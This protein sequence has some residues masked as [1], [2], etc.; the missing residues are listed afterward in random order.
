MDGSKSL[1]YLR[2]HVLFKT[3]GQS[4]TEIFFKLHAIDLAIGL[5]N[6][7]ITVI[8][9]VAKIESLLCE[10]HYTQGYIC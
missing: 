3:W 4:S 6:S 5:Q 8:A 9:V 1:E 2:A 7:I 10:R